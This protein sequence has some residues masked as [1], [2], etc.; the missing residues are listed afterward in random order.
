MGVRA[1]LRKRQDLL[2]SESVEH[3]DMWEGALTTLA[4]H[5]RDRLLKEADLDKLLALPPPILRAKIEALVSAMIREEKRVISHADRARLITIIT[6]EA[7]GY[8]PLEP[9]LRDPS[10]TEIMVNGPNE[11]YIERD[12]I[13]HRQL[14]VRFRDEDHIRH[15]IDR[16]VSPLGRRIDESSPMVDAR[17][18]DGSRVNA[19]IPPLSLNGPV[20]TIRRFRKDPL[21]INDL[22]RFGT[23]SQSMADFLRA[24]VIA[25]LNIIVCGGT[26]SGK[27]AT[28]N[29]LASFI[30]L[31]ER[32]ITIEDAA[33][34]QF[35]QVH[36]HVLR[37]EARPPNVEG[38]GEVTIRQLVRNALRMRPDRIIVGEVRGAEALDMLQAM[39]TGHEGCLST[40]HAN[41]PHDALSQLE[42]IVLWKWCYPSLPRDR[43]EIGSVWGG[44]RLL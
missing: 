41:T 36:P 34:L 39:N 28:L 26:G 43:T 30:P 3:P 18:P 25:K 21:T 8:D 14:N 13:L 6:N 15:I 37:Q 9:L 20:L 23:L 5:F 24:C 10:I 12:G 40:I 38:E 31:K 42:T 35:H 4:A 7:A 11:I 1:H 44:S 19:I 32:I 22:I 27:T 33:E 29:V 16:I 2:Y 17:L